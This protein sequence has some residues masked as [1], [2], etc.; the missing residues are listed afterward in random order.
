[1]RQF[2]TFVAVGVFNT[3]LG[4]FVIFFCMY[5][6]AWDPVVSNA[7]GYAVGLV[8]SY[9]LNRILTFRSSRRTLPEFISFLVVFLL[10]Y[11][12]NLA[13]LWILLNVG[14]HVGLSQILAGVLYVCASYLANKTL[15]F[16]RSSA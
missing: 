16:K 8:S 1:M 5:R 7:A 14:V 13:L 2:G 11:G 15:V 3:A 4:Y 9:L 12:A 6:L 10:A